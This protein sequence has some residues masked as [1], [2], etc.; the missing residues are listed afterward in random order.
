MN[1]IE[2]RLRDAFRADAKTVRPQDIQPFARPS[3]AGADRGR[4]QRHQRGTF[5]A[6]GPRRA[7]D[8][9]RGRIAVPLA[10][11]AAIAVIALGTVLVPRIWPG[12]SP[13]HQ[14]RVRHSGEPIVPLE[15]F[16]TVTT[17]SP[18]IHG[19]HL[20]R[21]GVSTLQLRSVR[22]GHVIATLLRSL[23]SIDAVMTRKHAV[24]A[25]VDDGCRSR[26]LR[27][28]PRTGA[29]TLIRTLPESAGSIA[30]SPDGRKLAY[31]T[32]PA[33][34]PQRCRP[35][36]QP[37]S[38]VR[39]Q[40]NPGGLPQFLPSVLA[41]VNLAT[42]T[43]ARAATGNPGNPAWSPAWSPDGSQI[44]VVYS[45]SVEL[46]SAAHPD[47]AAA[48]RLRPPHGCGYLA[49]TWTVTGLRAVLGCGK[50]NVALSPR[51]LVGLS[52]AGH[53]SGSWRLP[54]CIDGVTL[55]ADPTARHV[56]V[57]ADIGYG[58][59]P[60]CGFHRPGGWSIRIAEVRTTLT[61]VA[62]FPQSGTQLEVTGW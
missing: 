26:V 15:S 8:T 53:R 25:V 18:V 48:R 29:A 13:A 44:A 42:G 45:G 57:E 27:I 51:T 37:A 49:A 41:A 36:S 61:T 40:A 54:D 6:M 46:L 9:P 22:H 28:D 38:P 35:A 34:D 62:V 3:A 33:S 19:D 2:G 43:V 10:A 1:D 55:H 31:L 23:G 11:A 24:I 56:L 47:F 58:N 21:Y 50:E 4:Q 39:V 52:A 30:L 60:P 32:Y 14:G 5:R 59:D 12:S 17:T 7:A 20:I 16:L